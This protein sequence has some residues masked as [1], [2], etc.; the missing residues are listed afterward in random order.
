MRLLLLLYAAATLSL[1]VPVSA[2]PIAEVTFLNPDR[3]TDASP[4]RFVANERERD[5]TLAVLREHLQS[6]GARHLK[7]GDRLRIEVLDVDLAGVVQLSPSGQRDLRV[8][9]EAGAPEIDLR[10]V[11]VRAGVESS[12]VERVVDLGYLS[13]FNRCRGRDLCYEKIMLEQWFAR[14]FGG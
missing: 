1:A 4:T 9:R 10:Y 7:D 8:K 5:A 13:N 14:R 3:Y 6:L 11:L 12:G 2:Q